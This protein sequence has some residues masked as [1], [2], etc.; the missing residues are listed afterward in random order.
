MLVLMSKSRKCVCLVIALAALVVLD[1][2]VFAEPATRL[3]QRVREWVLLTEE[4]A[5]TRT[6][7]QERQAVMDDRIRLLQ[8]QIEQLTAAAGQADEQLDAAR[9]Q[10][11]AVD[12]RA[13]VANAALTDLSAPVRRA[14]SKARELLDRLPEFLL[15]SLTIP[16]TVGSTPEDGKPE[17]WPAR[18]KNA[19]GVIE[20]I[21]GMSA[22]LHEGR[23][24]VPVG[25]DGME[26][27]VLF[28][29]LAQA[30]GVTPDGSV[31]AVGRW[32]DGRWRWR[33]SPESAGVIRTALAIRRGDKP[34]SFVSLPLAR[35]PERSDAPETNDPSEA[36]E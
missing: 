11:D 8:A 20:D 29:G 6:D 17:Q 31:A 36:V 22:Q 2:A 7:W 18:L 25:E 10:L 15:D 3:R 14:E 13:S 1:T 21:Q 35:P 12:E 34:A 26:M 28:L 5:A 23:M 24:S 27:Q 30:F 4:L 16:D 9:D 32:E 19:L 33:E